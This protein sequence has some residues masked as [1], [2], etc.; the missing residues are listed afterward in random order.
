MRISHRALLALRQIK[1][2]LLAD[3]VTAAERVEA[4]GVSP[5]LL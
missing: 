2:M 4:D 1:L 3:W 5:S